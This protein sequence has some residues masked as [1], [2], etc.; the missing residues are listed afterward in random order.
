MNCALG[1][2]SKVIN[3]RELESRFSKVYDNATDT[4]IEYAKFGKIEEFND[5]LF[6]AYF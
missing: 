6:I 2:F 1:Q 3:N 5:F 4:Y